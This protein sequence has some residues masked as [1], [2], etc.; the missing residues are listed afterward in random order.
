VA[1]ALTTTAAEWAAPGIVVRNI[2]TMFGRCEGGWRELFTQSVFLLCGTTPVNKVWTELSLLKELLLPQQL[3]QLGD[4][5]R[6]MYR[7]AAASIKI[8][9]WMANTALSY[10][11]MAARAP[12]PK[13]FY[14]VTIVLPSLAAFTKPRL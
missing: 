13:R 5:R 1:G 14:C 10:T 12:A 11:A 2:S 4:V 8:V 9:V 7:H 6:A 3:R